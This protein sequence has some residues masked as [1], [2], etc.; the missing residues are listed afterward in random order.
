[1]KVPEEVLSFYDMFS[2]SVEEEYTHVNTAFVPTVVE[3][4]KRDLSPKLYEI[5]PAICDEV[6]SAIKQ[7]LPS[8]DD[9]TEI[10]TSKSMLDIVSKA[11]SHLFAGSDVSNN[12]DYL[13]CTRDYIVHLFEAI[14]EI[15]GTRPW[16]RPLLCPRLSKVKRLVV[17]VTRLK[18]HVKR[19]IEKRDQASRTDPNW[20]PPEDMMQWLINRSESQTDYLEGCAA[21]QIIL[22]LGI[23]NPVMLTLVSILH[24]LA[25]TPEYVEPLRE[26]IRN[27]LPNDGSISAQDLKGFWKLDSYLKETGQVYHPVIEPYFRSVRKGFTLSNGQFLPP[28]AT[29][30]VPNPSIITPGDQIFDGFRYSKLREAKPQEDQPNHRWLIANETEFRWGVGNHVCPG[31]FYAHHV[32]KITLIRLISNYDIRMPGEAQIGLHNRYPTI[33]FGSSVLPA[34]DKPLMVRKVKARS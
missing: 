2:K 23:I 29:V 3:T 14:K 10:N 18:S 17:T 15:K 25:V 1:R 31:R 33:E 24:T 30:V 20:N 6:D 11:S 28:S 8:H 12:A 13:E 32:I 21:A 19:V 5:T 7:Y 16:L 9:W 27:N 4:I 34:V 22:I 26:E